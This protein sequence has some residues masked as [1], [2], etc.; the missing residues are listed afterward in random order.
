MWEEYFMYGTINALAAGAGLIYTANAPPVRIDSNSDF[1][2][3]KNLYG[4]TNAQIRVALRDT[5]LGRE[6]SWNNIPLRLIASNFAGTPYILSAPYYILTGGSAFVLNASDASGAANVLRFV[7][8][9]AKLRSGIAPWE[10][11]RNV[12]KTYKRKEPYVYNTGLQVIGAGGVVSFPITI[13]NDAPFL[14]QKMTG[15]HN[16]AVGGLLVDIKDSTSIENTW[17][18]IPVPFETVFGN[19]QFPNVMYSFRLVGG[20]GSPATISIDVTNLT[21]FAIIFDIALHGL[22]LFA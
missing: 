17:S 9:G 8:H 11:D 6:L 10:Q 16:G 21:A 20:G 2:W 18:N 15:E 12:W 5:R 19:G 13:E 22:K 7:L 3:M 4:A 1:R 14:I